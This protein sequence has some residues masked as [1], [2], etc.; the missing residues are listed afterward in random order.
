MKLVK[1]AAW[2]LGHELVHVLE[3][4]GQPDPKTGIAPTGPHQHGLRRLVPEDNDGMELLGELTTELTAVCLGRN[5]YPTRFV[6][7]K[8][9]SYGWGLPL[10]QALATA[11]KRPI[12]PALFI[13]AHLEDD[14]ETEALGSQSAMIGLR[15][16]FQEAFPDRDIIEDISSL[17]PQPEAKEPMRQPAIDL[18]K[19]LRER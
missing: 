18:T 12:A 6:L 1:S 17:R 3:G 4:V 10:A 14:V 11:G 15:R 16:A 7:P 9:G 5:R 19:K 8:R 13:Q 2:T